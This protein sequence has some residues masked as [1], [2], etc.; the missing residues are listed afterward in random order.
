M[1][2]MEWIVYIAIVSRSNWLFGVQS[3]LL[4]NPHSNNLS[5]ITPVKK[6]CGNVCGTHLVLIFLFFS[7][8]KGNKGGIKASRYYFYRNISIFVPSLKLCSFLNSWIEIFFFILFF[9]N[10]PEILPEFDYI[11]HTHNSWSCCNTRQKL[12]WNLYASDFNEVQ[13]YSEVSDPSSSWWALN[14]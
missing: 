13:L 2:D 6:C 1:Q 7:K 10:K 5:K 11:Y 8:K 14:L 4:N 12:R 9:Y 3:F